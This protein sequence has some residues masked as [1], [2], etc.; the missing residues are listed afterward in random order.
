MPPSLRSLLVAL[1]TLLLC[2]CDGATAPPPDLAAPA[3]DASSAC[4]GRSQVDRP[5]DQAGY[6][7]HLLYVV[8]SDGQDRALDHQGELLSGSVASWGRWFREQTTGSSLRIDTCGGRPDLSFLRLSATDA[9]LRAMGVRV[10]DEIE[11]AVRAAGFTS[12]RKVYLAFYDGTTLDASCGAAPVPP[13][14]AFNVTAVYL[15]GEFSNANVPP[16]AQNPIAGA[17]AAPGYMEFTTLHEVL[18]TIGMAPAC[19]LHSAGGGHVNDSPRDV[20]YAG[21]QP[22]QPAALDVGN[23]D[24]YKA[25]RADCYDLSRSAFLDPL[26]PQAAPPPSW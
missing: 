17:A 6:Q 15:R 8:P 1:P 26:P 21:D 14:R 22:W 3:S 13:T 18:H 2:G 23:D 4:V 5:D 10:R 24:Y 11:R 19:S 20:M 16:C 7:I 25:G 12:D 9:Q